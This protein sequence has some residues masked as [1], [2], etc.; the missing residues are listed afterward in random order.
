MNIEA[1]AIVP[2]RQLQCLRVRGKPELHPGAMRMF[3]NVS[4]SF[5][6]NAQD[7]DNRIRLESGNALRSFEI[8]ADFG[9]RH[10]FSGQVLERPGQT[11]QDDS[12]GM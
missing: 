5:L 10:K 9:V 6:A 11:T 4:Q 3:R 1:G 12:L 7:V 2:D 8:G